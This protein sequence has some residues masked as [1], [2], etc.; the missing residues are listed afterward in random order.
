MK[1][2]IGDIFNQRPHANDATLER[3]RAALAPFLTC[4]VVQA[5]MVESMLAMGRH[6]NFSLREIVL[7]G[8]IRT[9]QRVG[10][11]YGGQHFTAA[12]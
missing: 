7:V 5:W 11:C 8:R 9:I 2:K 12:N 4:K 10:G 6:L 3:G 1:F